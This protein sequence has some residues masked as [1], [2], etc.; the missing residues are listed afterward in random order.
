MLYFLVEESGEI[1]L[2]HDDQDMSNVLSSGEIRDHL[3]Q[4]ESLGT[5]LYLK[6]DDS[7]NE[8]VLGECLNRFINETQ[9][10]RIIDFLQNMGEL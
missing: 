4:N 2:I 7:D 1:N 10:K 3:K 5:I 8:P 6:I 9:D